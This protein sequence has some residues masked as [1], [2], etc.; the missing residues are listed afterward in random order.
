MRIVLIG[1]G[2]IGGFVARTLA[3]DPRISLVAG[4]CRP[5]RQA[6]VRAAIDASIPCA[7]SLDDLPAADLMLECAGHQ[8][9][10]QYGAAILAGGTDL[11]TVSTGALADP[12]LAAILER[13]ARDGGGRLELASGAIGA[14]D[15]LQAAR[16]GG[17]DRV[18]YRGRKPPA[19]WRGSPAESVLDLDRLTGATVHFEG[20][21]GEAAR[22]YPKNANVAAT[23]ALAGL[24]LERTRAE[25]IAD[26]GI[27]ANIHEIEA[28][29]DFGSFYFRIA[30]R[31]LPDNPRSSALTAMSVVAAVRRRLDPVQI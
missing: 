23:V 14:L 2:A 7:Q 27:D 10:R 8:A 13:S 24:G 1:Y 29:G 3:A 16:A 19:G 15:A 12:D 18:V 11:V 31:G 20:T 30:G 22:R 17:L 6:A 9:L 5:G 28:S 25:L 4:L 21:A 26:P